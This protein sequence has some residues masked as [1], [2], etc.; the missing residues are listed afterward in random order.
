[1]SAAV[2]SAVTPRFAELSFLFEIRS[3][4]KNIP[5]ELA[6]LLEYQSRTNLFPC[7]RTASNSPEPAS[8]IAYAPRQI[9]P[10][11]LSHVRLASSRERP[12]RAAPS[13]ACTSGR[14]KSE[15][16]RRHRACRKENRNSRG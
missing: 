6:G 5:A 7:D 3:T 2:P 1:M 4:G 10:P 16:S 15:I 12:A 13:P 14:C 11:L 9:S 8:A